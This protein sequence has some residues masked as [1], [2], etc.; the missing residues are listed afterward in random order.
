MSGQLSSSTDRVLSQ[1]QSAGDWEPRIADHVGI[2]HESRGPP[3]VRNLKLAFRSVDDG[4]PEGD[5]KRDCGAQEL[6]I[7]SVVIGV[8]TVVVGI[9]AQLPQH[10]LGGA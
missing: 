4:F 8:A 2:T 3:P 7:V 5:R 1:K 10:C 6:I 9:Q